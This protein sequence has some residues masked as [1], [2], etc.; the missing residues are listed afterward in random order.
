MNIRL[1]LPRPNA[2]HIIRV[3]DLPQE[4]GPGTYDIS[5]DRETVGLREAA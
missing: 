5:N 3:V 1:E 2:E 4:R